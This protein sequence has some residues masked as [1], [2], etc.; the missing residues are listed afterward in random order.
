MNEH[1][2]GTRIISQVTFYNHST[3]MPSFSQ[4]PLMMITQTVRYQTRASCVAASGGQQ[5]YQLIHLSGCD[6]TV[7]A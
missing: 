3:R 4:G 5:V 2:N 1:F 7:V 6:Y